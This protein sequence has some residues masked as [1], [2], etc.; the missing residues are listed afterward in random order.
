VERGLPF[1]EQEMALLL[2][3]RIVPDAFGND[4]HFTLTQVD[5]FVLHLD[6]Q[7]T[8]QDE[9]ELI[10]VLMAVPCQRAVH[11]RDFDVG[12][13]NLGEDPGGPQLRE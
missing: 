8:F 2:G 6:P 1:D 13:I 3:D 5:R 10:L 12:V 7:T 9:E 11:F 4:E